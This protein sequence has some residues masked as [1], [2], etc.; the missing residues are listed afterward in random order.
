MPAEYL[1]NLRFSARPEGIA[2]TSER[3]N[4][5]H[6]PGECGRH[7]NAVSVFLRPHGTAG[8][9]ISK[10]LPILV[11]RQPRDAQGC[12]FAERGFSHS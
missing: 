8:T 9:A 3:P 11:V 1:P 10:T 2:F 6:G 12:A 7:V 5:P 4:H